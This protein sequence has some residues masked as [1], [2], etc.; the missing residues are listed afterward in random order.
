[1]TRPPR[2]AAEYRV[3]NHHTGRAYRGGQWQTAIP[4]P[5]TG[6][7]QTIRAYR[8][9]RHTGHCWHPTSAMADWSCCECG[10]TTGGAPADNCKLCA[11]KE[12]TR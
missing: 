6:L 7:R 3:A 8:C 5:A 1:M 4:L 9:R 10:A 12:T 11:A 2:T